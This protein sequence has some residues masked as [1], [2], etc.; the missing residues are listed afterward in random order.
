MTQDEA[1]N[2]NNKGLNFY[3]VGNFEDAVKAYNKAIEI[4]PE[5]VDYWY[6]KGFAL[7]ALRNFSEAIEAYDKTIDME[8]EKADAWYYKGLAYYN[9][10]I[11]EEA[12]KAFDKAKEIKPEYLYARYSPHVGKTLFGFPGVRWAFQV[13]EN[14]L[15]ASL[16]EWEKSFDHI[17][18]ISNE[19]KNRIR[20]RVAEAAGQIYAYNSWNAVLNDLFN[21]VVF[22]AL[23]FSLIFSIISITIWFQADRSVFEW[24]LVIVILLIALSTTIAFIILFEELLPE[25]LWYFSLLIYIII[26]WSFFKQEFVKLPEVIQDGISAGFTGGVTFTGIIIIGFI[27]VIFGNIFIE[28]RKKQRYPEAEVIDTLCEALYFAELNPDLWN[29]LEVK[30]ELLFDLECIASIFEN[31]LSRKII[32]HDPFTDQW[33]NK[34][35]R[36][37]AVG[38]RNLKQF[39]LLPTEESL[40]RLID[41]LGKRLVNASDGEWGKFEMINPS[42]DLSKISRISNFFRRIIAMLFPLLIIIIIEV[43]P[44]QLN[45]KVMNPII[46]ISVIWIIVN[47]V[48]FLDPRYLEKITALKVLSDSLLG[49][50]K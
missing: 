21:K 35:G 22:I 12:M 40:Q 38:I 6:N 32:S 2:W 8:P 17:N 15:R 49:H 34:C 10:G 16:K 4:N 39:I 42:T 45:E 7:H 31:E 29:E 23:I 28:W 33:L 19:T 48:A 36:K 25:K 44:I 24:M 3:D 37:I 9:L 20:P 46:I 13:Y 14:D 43:S 27:L 5:K 1:E 30:K 18:S 50:K 47:I 11:F 41:T 26:A